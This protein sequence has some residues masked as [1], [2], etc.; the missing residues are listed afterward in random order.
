VLLI[1]KGD[2]HKPSELSE[3]RGGIIVLKIIFC[4]FKEMHILLKLQCESFSVISM[5]KFLPTNGTTISF[6][7][8]WIVKGTELG[9]LNESPNSKVE[10]HRIETCHDKKYFHH[11][12][13][14]YRVNNNYGLR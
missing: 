6:I 5:L 1:L 11:H 13:I 10:C 9:I 4:H 7:G 12:L 8:N 3:E 2:L 14:S